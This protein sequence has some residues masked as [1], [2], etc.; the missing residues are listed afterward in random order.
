[1]QCVLRR[2]KVIDANRSKVESPELIVQTEELRQQLLAEVS[3]HSIYESS[4]EIQDFIK[5]AVLKQ[6]IF[7]YSQRYVVDGTVM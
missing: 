1:M 3:G 2:F 7:G 5:I 6:V 4:K